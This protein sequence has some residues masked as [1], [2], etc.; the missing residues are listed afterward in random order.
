MSRANNLVIDISVP[1]GT[2]A[3]MRRGTARGSA[4]RTRM[5]HAALDLFHRQGVHAT[6]VDQILEASETG[7]SQFYYYF[8]NKEGLIHAILENFY[9]NIKS[10]RARFKT[11]IA[12]MKD[13]EEWFRQYVKF[14]KDTGCQRSC[15]IGTI[16]NDLGNDQQLLRQDVRLIFDLMNRSLVDF[17][18]LLKGKKQLPSDCDPQALA[19]FCFS[20]MQGGLLIGKV[21]RETEPFEN[22]VTHAMRYLRHVA[23][24]NRK[25][26]RR[27]RA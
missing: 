20:I 2:I 1:Y 19:D 18:N 3:S 25:D 10:N 12:T 5:L 27:L 16:G 21:R 23:G 17:F 9:G 22:S 7:K 15:P 13:L 4:T 6:S 14:Q 26:A 24:S 8:K 11:K